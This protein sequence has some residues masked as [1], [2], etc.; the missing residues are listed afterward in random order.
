MTKNKAK[1]LAAYLKR[2]Q[3]NPKSRP[4]SSQYSHTEIRES[5]AAMSFGKCFYCERKLTDSEAEVDHFVEVAER[6]DLAFAWHNLCWSCRDCNRKKQSNLQVDVTECL[7]PCGAVDVPEE[8]L[9]FNQE[10]IR[11]RFDSQKGSRTIQKYRLDRDQLN[12]ARVKQL[13]EFDRLLRVIMK[14]QIRE[15]RQ[16]MTGREKE[17]LLSFGQADQAFSLMFQVYL[18]EL[19]LA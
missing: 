13:R 5:L 19:E 6:P 3:I 16:Q 14:K 10:Y 15:G 2:H 7:D 4:Y 9:S 18:A 12:Y 17:Y 11:P 8:H 1:W